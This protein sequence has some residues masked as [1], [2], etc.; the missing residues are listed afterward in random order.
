[1]SA[2]RDDRAQDR[3]PQGRPGAAAPA[4]GAD[5]YLQDTYGRDPYA[6]DPYGQADPLQDPYGAGARA[7]DP[8]AAA[9]QPQAPAQGQAGY[10]HGGYAQEGYG[11]ASQAQGGHPQEGY[12]QDGFAQDGYAQDGFAQ[13]GRGG[14]AW[15]SETTEYV[16]MDGLLGGPAGRGRAREEYTGSA[17][18]AGVAE[19]YAP[20]WYGEASGDL[21]AED[22]GTVPLIAVEPPLEEE[23]EEARG[24]DGAPR[25][26]GKVS[27]LLNS[28]AVM[29]AGTLVSRGTGFLRTMVIAAAIGMGLTGSSYTAAN[30]LPTLLYILVGGGA[31]NAVFVPQ[32]VR[33]M[34]ND[35]DG[36]T[37]YAN[38]LLTL[39]VVG[40]AGVVFLTVL[41]APL[42]VRMVSNSMMQNP[43]SADTTVALAR[44]CL[45]TIFFMGVHVVMGQILNARGRFGAM[46]WTPVLNNIVVIFTFG[47][48]IWAFGTFSTTKVQPGT[49]SPEGIRLL[50][51]GTLLGL[52]VQAL[53][54]IPYLRAAGFHYRPRFDWR[55]HGLGHAARLARWTF[56]FVLVNQA[57]F[58]VVTQLATA[59]EKVAKSHGFENVGLAAFS[60]AQLLWQL[61]QAVITVSVM[62]AVLP[63]I[64]RAASDGDAGAVRDDISYGLRTSAVAV[65]PAAFLFLALG[66]WIGSAIYDIGGDHGGRSAGYML[67]AF[68]LGLIP[69]SAQYVLLRGF[70]AYEDTRTPFS[71]T[72]W[73]AATNA[74]ASVL[75]YLLLPS[76]WAVTGMAAVYGLAY[77]V[78]VTVAVPKLKRRIG[79]ID[80]RRVGRTYSRLIAACVPSAAAGLC[81]ALAV[82]HLLSGWVGSVVALLVAV[83]VQ[84]AVFV[85]AA[86]VLRVEEVNSMVGMVRGRLGR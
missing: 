47:M 28:S 68:A 41:G 56:L 86:R 82:S 7:G 31:L 83:G 42:L 67:S 36:G 77:V 35:E 2:P 3:V 9:A 13:D 57:G 85:A 60:N 17:Y 79:D 63:R 8:Y 72:V 11:G 40:L 1:M 48:Y 71:N 75:C 38:R 15:D 50:G 53:A 80:G 51:I 4:P 24:G 37:A 16:G 54:M 65:V 30:T 12:A 74:V 62:S 69:Y 73:V 32:L 14:S 81:T 66:P 59:A 5:P 27:G 70:Y 20:N 58:L 33:S 21:H 78:G 49:I 61:P 34:K 19:E 22:S 45:P 18:E 23:A 10:A 64:S 26:G 25:K 52:A 6:A 55:G 46:M 39:V 84:L 76:Q 43:A 29:A 44:Y